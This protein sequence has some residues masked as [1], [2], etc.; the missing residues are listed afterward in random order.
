MVKVGGTISAKLKP[1][2]VYRALNTNKGKYMSFLHEV[3]RSWITEVQNQSESSSVDLQ[4]PE[5]GSL[6]G[7]ARQTFW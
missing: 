1:L 5:K 3:G 4:V 6:T 7:P 2:F